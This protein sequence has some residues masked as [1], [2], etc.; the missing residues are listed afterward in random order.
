MP[1]FL[2]FKDEDEK[3][4]FLAEGAMIT[5]VSELTRFPEKALRAEKKHAA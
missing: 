2:A 4:F 1:E 5:A 3:K